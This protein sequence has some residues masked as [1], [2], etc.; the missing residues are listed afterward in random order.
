MGLVEGGGQFGLCVGVGGTKVWLWPRVVK[1]VVSWWVVD[2]RVFAVELRVVVVEVSWV[3]GV[4][5]VKAVWVGWEGG[6]RVGMGVLAVVGGDVS[7]VGSR[8]GWSMVVSGWRVRGVVRGCVRGVTV[9][10]SVVFLML[11]GGVVGVSAIRLVV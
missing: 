11:T 7:W 5:S 1:A 10:D 6:W 3:R 9:W 2:S 8:G 4:M